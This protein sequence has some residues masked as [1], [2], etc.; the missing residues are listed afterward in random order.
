MKVGKRVG[1]PVCTACD[2]TWVGS[3]VGSV[4]GE[5][6]GTPVGLSVGTA[7]GSMDGVPVVFLHLGKKVGVSVR[8]LLGRNV[9]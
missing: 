7:V 3:L 5:S 4:V 8:S 1:S 9:G 2:G 6:E